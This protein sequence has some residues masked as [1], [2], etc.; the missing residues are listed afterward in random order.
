VKKNNL[1]DARV[2]PGSAHSYAFRSSR[3]HRL[4]AIT[5]A[6]LLISLAVNTHPAR[7]GTGTTA[8]ASIDLE[9]MYNAQV[10]LLATNPNG[11]YQF[12]TLYDF[13]NGFLQQFPYGGSSLRGPIRAEPLDRASVPGS[14]SIP[15]DPTRVVSELHLD[16]H[17][18]TPG[19]CYAHEGTFT[20]YVSF[21]LQNGAL[22]GVPLG[23]TYTADTNPDVC[24]GS[25]NGQ[26][27]SLVP[28]VNQLITSY[29]GEA[30][31]AFVRSVVGSTPPAYQSLNEVLTASSSST[32]GSGLVVNLILNPWSSRES[33]GFS[34]TS[35]PAVASWAPGRL[36][37]FVRGAD[38]ALWHRWY[39]GGWSGWESLGGYLTSDPAA[40]SW[41]GGRIDVFARGGDYGLWHEYFDA[42]WSGWSSLGGYLTS[43]PAVA[44]WAP[45]RLDVFARG[46][47]NEL[48]HDWYQGSWSGWGFLGGYFID[49]PAAVSWG[50]GRIDTFVVGTDSTVYHTWLD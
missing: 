12:S 23:E 39:Q 16:F 38:N 41:S 35:S 40:V 2:D 5:L 3:M 27:A 26:L 31:P 25:V 6:T 21:G 13:V 7:A 32:L 24:A 14:V 8:T 50:N 1:V 43:G 29:L 47:D 20:V 18:N 44:S 49:S 28:Q 4:I 45:G 33:L 11:P 15:N 42:G 22:T 37:V 34:A 19:G 36:D 48:W 17:M 9:Q 30:I 46:A 10:V